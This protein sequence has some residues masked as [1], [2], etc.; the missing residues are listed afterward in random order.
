M[1]KGRNSGL[2]ATLAR[3]HG[4]ASSRAAFQPPLQ[5]NSWLSSLPVRLSPRGAAE[6]G[7]FDWLERSRFG[8]LAVPAALYPRTRWLVPALHD[9]L[10]RFGSPP[11]NGNHF[12]GLFSTR[13]SML[14]LSQLPNM[15]NGRC[16]TLV[17]S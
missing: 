3:T 4:E 16:G 15:E 10:S 12:G 2:W 8:A 13:R 1:G 17:G 7:T 5:P 6:K 9:H 14:C 11:R